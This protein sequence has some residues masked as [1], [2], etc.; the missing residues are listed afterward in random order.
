LFREPLTR[1]VVSCAFAAAMCGRMPAA[2]NPQA[3]SE[4]ALRLAALRAIF[5]QAEIS[6][7]SRKKIDH[8][9]PRKPKSDELF[10]ADAF[11]SESV[12]EVIGAPMNEVEGCASENLATE[13]SS[14]TRQVRIEIFRWP[15]DNGDSGLL[16]VLQ[17]DFAG[18]SPA[19]A[20]PSIALLVR[21]V[22]NARGW[23]LRDQFLLE[24]THHESVQSIQLEDVTGD[25]LADLAVESNWGGAG[26]VGSSVQIFNL[27]Q[28][29]F[30][31]LL[32][33]NSRLMEGHEEEYTQTLEVT[34]SLSN[35]GKRFCF[36]KKILFEKGHS[37]NPPRI[38]HV[39]YPRGDCVYPREISDRN[40]M[41][42]RLH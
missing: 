10:F 17:Y 20:C 41:L 28:G 42:A 38:I 14:K 5:P 26:T 4:E 13:K 31:E 6:I 29:H 19:M 25:G 36:R 18:A 22:K 16:A 24:T 7:N 11:A 34:K 27:S 35:H 12:Y 32:S 8:S 23:E 3:I 37:F 9:W 2:G 21:L 39:C 1:A 40:R 30:T 33:A 15:S